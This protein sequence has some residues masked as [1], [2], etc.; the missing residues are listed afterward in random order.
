MIS[1]IDFSW[2]YSLIFLRAPKSFSM[3]LSSG[4]YGGRKSRIAPLA[5]IISLVFADL[6][7]VAQQVFEP[8][9]EDQR[10]A[11][12]FPELGCRQRPIGHAGGQ[13]RDVRGLR[14]PERAP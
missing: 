5:L 10:V 9:I 13:K 2:L 3:G 6:W 4:E 14:L 8:L 11:R 7:K 12:P 1:S